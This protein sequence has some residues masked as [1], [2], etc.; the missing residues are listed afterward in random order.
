MRIGMVC[1]YSLDNPGG[2]QIHALELCEHLRRNGHAVSLVAPAS[3]A[4]PA[5][6]FVVKSGAAIAIPYNGSVARLS[7]TPTAVRTVKNWLANGDFDLVHIH[8][9][10]APS[11]SM[12]ALMMARV[13]VVATYHAFA[14]RS[15]LLDA[16]RPALQPLLE[17][18]S[19]GIAVSEMARQWQI[20]QI[21]GDPILIPNGVET[22]AYATVE[23]LEG[24]DPTRPRICFVGRF[25][26]PRKG[27]DVII[28]GLPA[29]AR[30]VPNVELVVVGVGD[31]DALRRRTAYL[32]DNVRVLGRL[33]DEDKARALRASDIYVA[34][35]LGG[36]SFGIVLVEAMATHTAVVASDIPAFRSV[37]DE[38]NA[39]VLFSAGNT[40]ELVG[41]VVDLLRNPE[42]REAVAAAGAARAQRYDWNRVTAD[43]LRVYETV[44]G[45]T[46]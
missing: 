31:D 16:V 29:I 18:I 35:H 19:A 17:K 2:V 36:E 25:D 8:E 22:S 45:H 7:F 21:G 9:P 10:N 4:T 41:H 40:S 6:D 23:P 44:V 12:L 5:P 38:G 34:P 20:K 11:V 27:L 37:L 3:A 24:L 15:L 39:G 14:D 13:P 46:S 30:A 43:V 32:S 28:D 26:E 42:H 33:S 1:P